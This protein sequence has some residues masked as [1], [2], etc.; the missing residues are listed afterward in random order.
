MSYRI[1][2]PVK[3]GVCPVCGGTAFIQEYDDTGA[4]QYS[5][6]CGNPECSS[7]SS[8]IQSDKR[9]RAILDFL[10]IEQPT[11]GQDSPEG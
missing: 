1:V 5:V 6:W 10:R 4:V 3:E 9:G 7:Y 11:K 2:T 8:V